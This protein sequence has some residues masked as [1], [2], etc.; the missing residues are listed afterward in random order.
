MIIKYHFTYKFGDNLENE[1]TAIIPV[2]EEL[3]DND[4]PYAEK[5]IAE[6]LSEK[7][8]KITEYS[9]YKKVV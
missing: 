5:Y 7:N 2:K 4:I 8:V 1:G 3:D 6:S 9:L